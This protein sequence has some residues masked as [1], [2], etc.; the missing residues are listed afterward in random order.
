M[1]RFRRYPRKPRIT[2][3]LGEDLRSGGES[4]DLDVV[5]DQDNLKT[6]IKD[7]KSLDQ[8]CLYRALTLT[9][10][11]A[12]YVKESLVTIKADTKYIEFYA[13]KDGNN[14]ERLLATLPVAIGLIQNNCDKGRLTFELGNKGNLHFHCIV[15]LKSNS[16]LRYRNSISNWITQFGFVDD[17]PTRTAEGRKIWTKYIE[18]EWKET[19]SF[20]FGEVFHERSI[21]IK[22]FRKFGGF[23]R[24]KGVKRV[25]EFR[26]EGDDSTELFEF[27][28]DDSEGKEKDQS[29]KDRI[30]RSIRRNDD[31]RNKSAYVEYE[32][33]NVVKIEDNIQDNIDANV[34]LIMEQGYEIKKIMMQMREDQYC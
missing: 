7:F 24:D 34:E 17:K 11:E 19:Q 12:K 30:K 6:E 10:R 26:S 32:A 13:D 29:N 18:K 2:Q 14:Y 16:I 20:F 28:T 22:R 33:K 23:I 27:D 3:K 5:Q 8:E 15:K 25:N 9:V 1:P 31:E 4:P 21:N